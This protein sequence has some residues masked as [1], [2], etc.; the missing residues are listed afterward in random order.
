MPINL[1][2]SSFF[3]VV[4]SRFERVLTPLE[5]NK[6]AKNISFSRVCIF[7]NQN[8]IIN[9]SVE[10]SWSKKS[11][12]VRVQEDGEEWSPPSCNFDSDEDD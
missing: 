8:N 2:D 9:R 4:A 12:T 7:T 5:C 1:G 11:F 6:E 3:E 10:V